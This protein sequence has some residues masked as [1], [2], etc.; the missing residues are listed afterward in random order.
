M[1]Y[2]MS[3]T[4][5]LISELEDKASP[6][7]NLAETEAWWDLATR[8]EASLFFDKRYSK[9]EKE[10]VTHLKSAVSDAIFAVC[11]GRQPEPHIIHIPLTSLRH[12]VERRTIGI[13]G[14]PLRD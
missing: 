14:N 13:D 1:G 7:A 2:D 12:S 4:L 10:A 8:I 11:K 3:D 6:H 5:A 9:A